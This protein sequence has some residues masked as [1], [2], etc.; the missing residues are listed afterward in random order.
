M[1]KENCSSHTKRIDSLSENNLLL[2]W[3]EEWHRST[4]HELLSHIPREQLISVFKSP[5]CELDESYLWSTTQYKEIL[6]IV[7]KDKIIIDLWCWEAAQSF[8]F[9]DYKRYIWVDVVP[10]SYNDS[11]KRNDSLWM[12]FDRFYTPNTTHYVC[13]AKDFLGLE[14][15]KLN[16]DANDCFVIMC[17]IPDSQSMINCLDKFPNIKIYF[18]G[19]WFDFFRYNWKVIRDNNHYQRIK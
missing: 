17:L 14:F 12:W 18:P 7:P 5:F 6:D 11:I 15:G 1:E 10:M 19:I 16:I 2:E 9:K 4:R 13:T 3:S 8:Y